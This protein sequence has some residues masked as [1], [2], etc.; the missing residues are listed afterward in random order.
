MLARAH[1]AHGKTAIYAEHGTGLALAFELETV[2]NLDVI[3][4]LELLERL[5]ALEEGRG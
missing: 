3:A 4:N 1:Q 5:L 2:A